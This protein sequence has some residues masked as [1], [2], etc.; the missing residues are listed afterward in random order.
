MRVPR[1][2]ENKVYA[3]GKA[4]WHGNA[5]FK[6]WYEVTDPGKNGLGEVNDAVS[7]VF[8]GDNGETYTVTVT[9][10]TD[11]VTVELANETDKEITLENAGELSVKLNVGATLMAKKATTTTAVN[12]SPVLSWKVFQMGLC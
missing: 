5:E 11:Q 6:I 7:K 12:T 3:Q 1:R 9:P 10:V 8:G 4:N 2:H